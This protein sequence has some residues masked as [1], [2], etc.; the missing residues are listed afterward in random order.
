MTANEEIV[1]GIVV[2]SPYGALLGMEVDRIERDLVQIRLPYRPEVV[3]VADGPRYRRLSCPRGHAAH[4]RHTRYQ[5]TGCVCPR[6]NRIFSPRL[7][8]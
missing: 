6:A 7:I 5:A 8:F 1:H 2:R 3:T 4:L